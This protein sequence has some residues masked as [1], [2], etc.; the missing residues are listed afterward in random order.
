MRR[1][2][3]GA[4]AVALTGLI[5][6]CALVAPAAQTR[7]PTPTPA[8]H[9]PDRT[10]F[11]PVRPTLTPVGTPGAEMQPWP[12]PPSTSTFATGVPIPPPVEPLPFPPD[13]LN[14][15][16]LGSD[17]RTSAS[18]R[19]DTILLISV[20]PSA[21]GVAIVSIPR[22]LYVY[23]PGLGM[24]RINTAVLYGDELKY[25][26]GGTG[27]LRD[28]LL[29]NL[30]IPVQRFARVE[31]GGFVALVNAL[32]GVDVPV[33]CDYTDWQL[34]D[35]DLKPGNAANWGLHTV[36]TG[37]VHMDGDEALWYARSRARSSDFDRARRQQEVLRALHQQA[38]RLDLLI[39][40]PEAYQ[41][42]LGWVATDLTLEDALSLAPLAAR[43]HAV[44]IRSRFIGRDQVE[45][46]RLPTSGAAVLLPPPAAIRQLLEDAFRF[47][48][49]DARQPE[50]ASVLLVNASGSEDWAGLATQRLAY[51]GFHVLDGGEAPERP[52]TLILDHGPADPGQASHLL[53]ALGL[54][55]ER[56][57]LE[58]DPKAVVPLE[59]LLGADYHPCFDPTRHQPSAN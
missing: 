27:L 34:K 7:E 13:S 28:T 47:E 11:S 43:L 33:A 14:I 51:F 29:F 42:L 36:S 22:D 58:P 50:A 18:F 31:M 9:L 16:L 4:A 19:T 35:P 44:D 56:L 17:R 38:L 57:Q 46:I 30:G 53:L 20:Q 2:G 48:V 5:V 3:A 15:V 40:I 1:L 39:R 8:W 54:L 49:P 25:P 21:G 6:A 45:E 55:P 52:D 12:S 32:G 23:L 41:E 37:I 26:G 10:P 24:Q 59:V